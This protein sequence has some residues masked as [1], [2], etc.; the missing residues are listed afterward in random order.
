MFVAINVDH[1][2]NEP[3][4][5]TDAARAC[6]EDGGIRK[7]KAFLSSFT[8]YD[9]AGGNQAMPISIGTSNF[10]GAPLPQQFENIGRIDGTNIPLA[11]AATS[12]H[13][14]G[15]WNKI[16]V[17]T[18]IVLH[19]LSSDMLYLIK[20]CLNEMM[21]Y[22]ENERNMTRA[23]IKKLALVRKVKWTLGSVESI[24]HSR[25]NNG[26]SWFR[27]TDMI[28]MANFMQIKKQHL[29]GLLPKDF[30]QWLSTE[31]DMPACAGWSS[32]RVPRELDL[33]TLLCLFSRNVRDEVWTGVLTS[34]VA[35]ECTGTLKT[36]KKLAVLSE[37]A[38]A[39]SDLDR[40]KGRLGWVIDNDALSDLRQ[41]F[42]LRADRGSW[43]Q[44]VKAWSDTF[45][46]GKLH[47]ITVA[48]VGDRT[49]QA[50]PP[51][52]DNEEIKRRHDITGAVA[53]TTDSES[54]Q[55]AYS[56]N[57]ASCMITN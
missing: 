18:Q 47:V 17:E 20:R 19:H 44:S 51:F 14:I 22:I 48:D 41:E 6:A 1:G 13:D 24:I 50:E 53:N 26:I 3:R 36:P 54:I 30:V 46:H 25:T 5:W 40:I 7:C 52:T 8:A 43:W 12:Q 56:S 38:F 37:V 4:W 9:D 49:M 28:P 32:K 55:G 33:I 45:P 21:Y 39:G 23:Q 16:P 29:H 27:R 31:Q 57:L 34:I 35:K 42:A 11:I 2:F 10:Q 15:Y